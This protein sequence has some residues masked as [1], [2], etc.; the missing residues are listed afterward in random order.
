MLPPSENRQTIGLHGRRKEIEV[1]R[2]FVQR[3]EPPNPRGGA[4]LITGPAGIGKTRLM[5][6]ARRL[7]RERGIN[8]RSDCRPDDD[9]MAFLSTCWRAAFSFFTK[10]VNRPSSR[11]A[12]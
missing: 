4:L 5:R 9:P 1:L 3:V 10:S 11:C 12:P 6:E 7:V 2:R 8:A